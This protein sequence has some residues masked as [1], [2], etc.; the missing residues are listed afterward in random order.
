ME[1]IDIELEPGME[2]E[3]LSESEID[4]ILGTEHEA[5]GTGD[6]MSEDITASE[7]A[8]D[9]SSFKKK[10]LA[11]KKKTTEAKKRAIQTEQH[12]QQEQRAYEEALRNEQEEFIKRESMYTNADREFTGHELEQTNFTKPESTPTNHNNEFRER[13]FAQRDTRPEY[14]EYKFTESETVDKFTEREFIPTN[15]GREYT[16]GEF[17][18]VQQTDFT[19]SKPIPEN[20]H[21]DYT[22]RKFTK[23]ETNRDFMESEPVPA[24]TR[25]EYTKNKLTE[26]ETN[27]NYTERESVPANDDIE[28][29]EHKTIPFKTGAK[30]TDSKIT[31]HQPEYI[32]VPADEVTKREPVFNSYMDKNIRQ[33]PERYEESAQD[34]VTYEKENMSADMNSYT[35]RYAY[36]VKETEPLFTEFKKSEAVLSKHKEQYFSDNVKGNDSDVTPND[37]RETKPSANEKESTATAGTFKGTDNKE[38]TGTDISGGRDVISRDTHEQ[39]TN[40]EDDNK[41]STEVTETE[42]A[43]G[44]ELQ[45]ATKRKFTRDGGKFVEQFANAGKVIVVTAADEVLSQDESGTVEMVKKSHHYV[46]TV[47]DFAGFFGSSDAYNIVLDKD[48]HLASA[49]SKV[50]EL[51]SDGKL[52]LSDLSAPDLP[53]KLKELGL[54][55]KDI[56]RITHNSCDIKDMFTAREAM[57]S[58]N[59]A[60]GKLGDQAVDFFQSREYFHTGIFTKDF[61]G[62]ARTYFAGHKDDLLRKLNPAGMTE[63]E[64]KRLLKDKKI[65]LSPV[66][67]SIVNLLYRSKRNARIKGRN[68]RAHGLKNKLFAAGNII[69]NQFMKMDDPAVDG[70]RLTGQVLNGLKT[71]WSVAGFGVHATVAVGSVAGKV[72]FKNPASRFV[73]RQIKKGGKIVKSTVKTKVGSTKTV[74][75]LLE[76]KKAAVK[77]VNQA[78]NVI[79][80]NKGVK[81]VKSVVGSGRKGAHNVSRTG[82]KITRTVRRVGGQVGRVARAPLVVFKPIAFIGRGLNAIREFIKKKILIPICGVILFILLASMGLSALSGAMMSLIETSSKVVLL[83]E[84]DMQALVDELNSNNQNIYDGALAKAKEAPPAGTTVY[85]G[86]GLYAYGSPRSENDE[87]SEWYHHSGQ[88]IDKS[89]LNGWHVYYLDSE[90]N[91]I[92]NN[93]NNTKDIICL[94]ATMMENS[95]DKLQVYRHICNDIWQGMKPVV[96]TQ[97]SDIYHTEYSTDQYP[98]D[99]SKYYCNDADFYN[100]YRASKDGGVCFY[101]YPAT[102]HS[103]PANDEGYICTGSGCEYEEWDE[104][105]LICEEDEHTHG[106]GCDT[107]DCSHTHDLSCLRGCTHSHDDSCCSKSEHTHS[108]EAGCYRHDF[109]RDYYCPGHDAL[110]VSYGYQDINVY[111]TLLQKEDMYEA[112]TTADKSTFTF[113]VPTNYECTTFETRTATVSYNT[114]F[115]DGYKMRMKHFN[116]HGFWDYEKHQRFASISADSGNL[117]CDIDRIEGTAFVK[118]TDADNRCAGAIEQC[119][120]FFSTDWF[121]AYGVQVYTV[122]SGLSVGGTLSD[123]EIAAL[124]EKINNQFGSIDAARS[125]LV[126]FALDKVG[127]IKYWWG[128][129]PSGKSWDFKWGTIAPASDSYYA[130]NAAKGRKVYGL[131]CS[132]FVGWCYW[133]VFDVQPGLSTANFTTSL[134]LSQISFSDM[135]PGDIGLENRPGSKTN[136]IGIFVGY[137]ENGKAMWVHCNG[138]T[139]DVAVNNTNCFRLYY[140][141]IP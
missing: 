31:N 127:A 37:Y 138:S 133:N 108:R 131:D 132:G 61:T 140:Q 11:A 7:P 8:T 34:P 83:K 17:M 105:V 119:D 26:P 124:Q 36:P 126:N 113:K 70:M 106:S 1:D 103:E 42:A 110:H 88:L 65:E 118:G 48:L 45:E 98:F 21:E 30:F 56:R 68:A 71:G 96:T 20:S 81:T 117:S 22:E 135:R 47:A 107:R 51:I 32:Q 5:P 86:V 28:F 84:E 116:N 10:R 89:K 100:R 3:Q 14:T 72:V 40:K 136:H 104:W 78:K 12:R 53:D 97:I 93:V 109:H 95:T 57:L 129:K 94:A 76:K 63:K 66:D 44:R 101:E 25:L 114:Y 102:E 64:L 60:T 2:S 73:G 59:T 122:D 43:S 50:G 35:E 112:D 80:A 128:G 99:G 55:K 141:L 39:K 13:E 91:V 41:L 38:P 123:E 121:E 4:E 27:N 46:Q 62:S 130:S 134:G 69:K 77:T 79:N 18:P 82:K 90:G 23:P 58:Y 29:T 115:P 9:L 54:S 85:D 19:D 75:T 137:D 125:E 74:K 87:T 67:R 92:G 49:A 111:V 120:L 52:K 6:V 16:E 24:D 139:G 15:E 33:R